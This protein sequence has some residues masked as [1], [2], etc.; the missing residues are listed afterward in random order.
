MYGPLATITLKGQKL[1]LRPF[2]G[3]DVQAIVRGFNSLAVRKWMASGPVY[4]T[5][6]QE[7]DWV[8]SSASVS[9]AYFWAIC[10]E[11]DGEAIGSTNLGRVDLRIGSAVSGI[12]IWRPDLHGQGIATRA[13]LARTLFAAKFLRLAT[14]HSSA[15][16]PNVASRRALERVGYVKVGFRPRDWLWD[17]GWCDSVLLSWTNPLR[18]REVWG[19][20]FRALPALFKNDLLAGRARAIKALKLAER[21]VRFE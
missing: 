4:Q 7:L 11:P 6:A 10:L 5:E 8:R 16:A 1:Y 15:R 3:S 12:V 19:S 17:Y 2:K 21:C 14:I 13:H 9:D 18:W 20:D